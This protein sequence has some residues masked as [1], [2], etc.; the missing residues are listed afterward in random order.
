MADRKA[1]TRSLRER[2]EP[3]QRSG[4]PHS[5]RAAHTL[6]G[7]GSPEPPPFCETSKEVSGRFSPNPERQEVSSRSHSEIDARLLV[8][9]SPAFPVGAFAFSHGLELAAD[10][11]WV[12][13]RAGVEAWL[14]DLVEKGALRNDL[15]LLARA[16]RAEKTADAAALR[17]V[18]ALALALQPS[19]ERRL[20]TVTQGN[21]FMS[22]IAAAWPCDRQAEMQAA[23]DGDVAYPVAV[24]VV[25]AAHGCDLSGVLLAY[26]LAFVS[27]LT[28][29]AIRL[30]L[31]GQTDGQ[32]V[33]AAL[34]P[35]L[36]RQAA[37]AA[38]ATL[39]D[40]GS[41]TLRSDLASLAHETQYSRLFR[42]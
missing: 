23:V 24:G 32:R 15:I 31:I 36:E 34:M 38:T 21:A 40:V 8:W 27:N 41:A 26:A 35:S 2:S 17:D 22:T 13:D 7:D 39:D 42:S 30:S 28:S 20:E 29:A 11:G 33:I 16:W 6:P 18:N 12:R 10:R 9:L 25:A 14:G 5:I 37:F 19:A 1:W 4:C 3:S